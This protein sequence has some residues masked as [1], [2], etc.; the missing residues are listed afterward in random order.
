MH[1][2]A[3]LQP[4][5]TEER[6]VDVRFAGLAAGLALFTSTT[7]ASLTSRSA[8]RA[9]SGR[10]PRPDRRRHLSSAKEEAMSPTVHRCLRVG[11][12][13]G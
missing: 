2:D 13:R 10:R 8:L 5:A 7:T 1:L 6:I 12:A 4:L 3:R 11:S 9:G